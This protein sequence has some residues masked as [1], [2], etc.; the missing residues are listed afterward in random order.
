MKKSLIAI[1]CL[2][3]L[4]FTALLPAGTIV[5]GHSFDFEK[6][7]FIDGSAEKIWTISGPGDDEPDTLLWD[8]KNVSLEKVSLENVASR[9][10]LKLTQP[11]DLTTGSAT[12]RFT[13]PETLSITGFTWN[14][15]RLLLNGTQGGDDYFAWQYSTDGTTWTTFYERRNREE[16]ERIID[17]ANRTYNVSISGTEINT[18]YVR[19]V[20]I[21]GADISKDSGYFAIISDT[22]ISTPTSSII[23]QVKPNP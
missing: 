3:Y 8:A 5:T 10:Q 2:V 16:F 1:A 14:V 6:S 9:N 7:D 4:V 13:V 21:E 20:L 11:A 22:D 18:L 12:W 17:L 15:R 23:L 19:A